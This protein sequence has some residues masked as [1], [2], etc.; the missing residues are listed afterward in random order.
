VLL[1][2]TDVLLPGT[3][4]LLPGTDADPTFELSITVIVT[5]ITNIITT[6]TIFT[7]P[8]LIVITQQDL[9]LKLVIFF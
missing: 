6:M 9:K 3:D 2:V 8:V 5:Q 1:L 4:V 7:P